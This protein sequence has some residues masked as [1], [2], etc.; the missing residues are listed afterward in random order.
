[1]RGGSPASKRHAIFQKLKTQGE[2]IPN[3]KQLLQHLDQHVNID[4]ITGT[5]DEVLAKLRALIA[6]HQLQL[7]DGVW[8]KQP[9]PTPPPVDPL[10]QNDPWNK[11]SPWSQWR[12]ITNFVLEGGTTLPQVDL[13][14]LQGPEPQGVA[15][16]RRDE[17]DSAVAQ[18]S[19]TKSAVALLL[20]D[21][22]AGPHKAGKVQLMVTSVAVENKVVPGWLVVLGS[23]AVSVVHP[24]RKVALASEVAMEMTLTAH[25]QEMEMARFSVFQQR[26]KLGQFVGPLRD[27]LLIKAAFTKD[28][29]NG[30]LHTYIVAVPTAQAA[31]LMKLSGSGGLSVGSS[32]LVDKALNL[33]TVYAE[34]VS[35][36]AV[37]QKV[38]T[39]SHHGVVGPLRRGGYLVRCR[40]DQVAQVRHCVAP[41]DAR[42]AAHPELVVCYKYKARVSTS[43]SPTQLASSLSM[44]ISWPCVGL[45]VV[46][47]RAGQKSRVHTVLIGADTRAPETQLLVGDYLVRLDLQGEDPQ[48]VPVRTMQPRSEPQRVHTVPDA[49]QQQLTTQHDTLSKCITSELATATQMLQAEAQKDRAHVDARMEALVAESERRAKDRESR[50]EH[51]LDVLKTQQEHQNAQT[52][53]IV[54]KLKTHEADTA[55]LKEAVDSQRQELQVFGQKLHLQFEAFGKDI[56]AQVASMAKKREGASSASADDRQSKA[57]KHDEEPARMSGGAHSERRRLRMQATTGGC[58]SCTYDGTCNPGVLR[59]GVDSCYCSAP[60]RVRGN[61]AIP[62]LFHLIAMLCFHPA[63]SDPSPT[64]GSPLLP[65]R[66]GMDDAAFDVLRKKHRDTLSSVFQQEESQLVHPNPPQPPCLPQELQSVIDHASSCIPNP[67]KDLPAQELI[68]RRW[69]HKAHISD[70]AWRDLEVKLTEQNVR[71]ME[72]GHHLIAMCH[73]REISTPLGVDLTKIKSSR[74]SPRFAYQGWSLVC[75]FCGKIDSI[76]HRTSM[77]TTCHAFGSEAEFRVKRPRVVKSA[78][79]TPGFQSG[80]A[81]PVTPGFMRAIPPT[82]PPQPCAGA[83]VDAPV[84]SGVEVRTLNTRGIAS[85]FEHL[86]EY[87]DVVALQET[88]LAHNKAKSL[89]KRAKTMGKVAQFALP[90]SA[91]PTETIHPSQ[92]TCVIAGGEWTVCKANQFVQSKSW[93]VQN[94][95]LSSGCFSVFL[96]NVY[97]VSGDQ[98][99][100]W[101]RNAELVNELMTCASAFPDQGH[102]IAGDFQTDVLNRHVFH[103]L[104][105]HGWVSVRQRLGSPNT[106]HASTGSSALDDILVSPRLV[107]FIRVCD[108]VTD[109]WFTDHDMLMVELVVKSVCS[110]GYR[111]RKPPCQSKNIG[112][113]AQQAGLTSTEWWAQQECV[114]N[115]GT[116]LSPW[117]RALEQWVGVQMYDL[118]EFEVAPDIYKVT[119]QALQH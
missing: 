44:S 54:S 36:T 26:D 106:F 40:A 96:H 97:F 25:T 67:S 21:D 30:R 115:P 62:A 59:E 39:I 1:M 46:K 17:L 80:C 33:T 58:T 116:E 111:L 69:G 50:L 91:H 24:A 60:G 92:G 52:G 13:A 34:S 95:I 38:S 63:L 57:G 5:P 53:E 29:A 47:G 94:S 89:V 102:I 86:V 105:Q 10:V 74:P 43:L 68:A 99:T 88:G 14:S 79:G 109:L 61:R 32:P 81:A 85:K 90:E 19:D 45:G 9:A 112:S 103:D 119:H 72:Q 11:T 27:Y 35:A 113:V 51:Q 77:Q 100:W 48:Q 28:V 104:L 56:L 65:L 108:H 76:N 42:Y 83:A 101:Q 117:F 78:A 75:W 8:K 20:A 12:L 84:H 15:L 16:I 118:G 3:V 55:K 70:K 31:D 93:R 23:Q 7:T 114:C 41:H 22:P 4:E 71:A 18:F 49:L 82:P 98:A 37:I 110:Y 64:A 107:P 73:D 66:G 87:N 2:Q 6:T